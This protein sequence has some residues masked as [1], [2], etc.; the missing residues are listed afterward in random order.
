M[1]V[2]QFRLTDEDK[3]A[4]NAV[5]DKV[6]AAVES[7]DQAE[8][9]AALK[10]LADLIQNVGDAL[11]DDEFV[12]SDAIIPDTETSVEEARSMLTEEGLIPD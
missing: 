11:A 5:D 2:G 3:E 12:G 8:F 9:S 1:G 6:M 4:V 7:G 10:T